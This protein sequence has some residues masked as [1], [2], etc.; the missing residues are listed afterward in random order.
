MMRRRSAFGWLE[1]A[2]GILLVILGVFVIVRT[3]TALTGVV[4]LY[5]LVAVITGISDIVLYVKTERYTGFAP[6]ISMITGVLSVMAGIM[7]L[8]YPSAGKWIIVLLLPIW[9]IAHCISRL[10][11]LHIIRI[12]VG[13]FYYYVTLIVNCIGLVLG[14]MMILWPKISL[15]A[16]GFLIGA[17]LI[18][19]GIDSIVMAASK[20]GSP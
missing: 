19:S 6:V 7:L 14:C 17:Y 10:T 12:A 9:F 20:I 15:F 13:N 1:L 4:M 3:D 11:H 8:V 18:L 5:G 16:V 2:V